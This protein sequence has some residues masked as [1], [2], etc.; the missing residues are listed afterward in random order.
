MDQVH[1]TV[2]RIRRNGYEAAIAGALVAV[3]LIMGLII[4]LRTTHGDNTP[5]MRQAQTMGQ[6]AT[7]PLKPKSSV[8]EPSRKQSQPSQPTRPS[9]RAQSKTGGNKGQTLAID[10][11][12]PTGGKQPNLAA[13]RNLSV[14]VDLA[15]QRVYVLSGKKTIYTAVVS[16]GMNGS[17]PRGHFVAGDHSDTPRGDSF[18]NTCEKMGAKNWIRIQGDILFHSVPTD[19]KESYITSEARKL[20]RPASHGCVRM[21]VADS[22]WFFD[23]L[24]DGTPVRIY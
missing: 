10:W 4:G 9:Q 19:E 24:P 21:S 2:S 1:Q 20:G 14:E 5:Q 15:K 8:R 7:T 6:E 18:F 16:T 22:K 3:C 17:T 11:R 23:Q 13:Y 12:K